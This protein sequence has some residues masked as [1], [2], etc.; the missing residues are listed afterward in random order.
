MRGAVKAAAPA[1]RTRSRSQS[2]NP[3]PDLSPRGGGERETEAATPRPFSAPLGD[4]GALGDHHDPA[5]GHV[6]ALA[7]FLEVDAIFV[8]RWGW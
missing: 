7:V 4:V 8:P 1:E 6:E 2:V 3:S 5:L